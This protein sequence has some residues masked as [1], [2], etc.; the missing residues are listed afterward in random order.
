MGDTTVDTHAVGVAHLSPFGS[1]DEA[2]R[3]NFANG[4]GKISNSK[5]GLIG[6][7]PLYAEAL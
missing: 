2:V 1:N 7:Y 3:H 5:T 6:T 4:A